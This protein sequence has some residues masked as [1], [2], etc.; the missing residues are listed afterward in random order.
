MYRR[1]RDN[2]YV[3]RW[4]GLCEAIHAESVGP[5]RRQSHRHQA[6]DH[7]QTD[8]VQRY[9]D[10]FPPVL[11]VCTRLLGKI[12]GPFE[13]FSLVRWNVFSA[14]VTI[15]PFN[16]RYFR[17]YENV[18]VF[19]V[20][21]SICPTVSGITQKIVDE[22]WWN[23][24]EWWYVWLARTDYFFCGDPDHVA[25]AGIYKRSFGTICR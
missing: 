14:H 8:H 21:L 24:S 2:V 18:T 1:L 16:L 25:D 20:R 12:L 4:S 9:V 17:T 23:F 7:L 6:D 15:A 5:V 10:L 11:H 19:V 3:L 22:F 13:I